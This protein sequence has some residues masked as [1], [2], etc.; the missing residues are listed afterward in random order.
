MVVILYLNIGH[1]FFLL[2]YHILYFL[3]PEFQFFR[4]VLQLISILFSSHKA[5]IVIFGKGQL[6]A[7][8]VEMFIDLLLFFHQFLELGL[9]FVL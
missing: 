6:R 3:P 5:D 8:I 7:D 9:E 2:S 1:S 4:S